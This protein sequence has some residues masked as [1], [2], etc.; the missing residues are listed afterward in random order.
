MGADRF[1]DK[2]VSLQGFV[3]HGKVGR[4][5]QRLLHIEMCVGGKFEP[6][7]PHLF[8]QTAE[9]FQSQIPELA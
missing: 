9:V 8:C 3:H 7:I 1:A 4:I 5:M 2:A 6:I